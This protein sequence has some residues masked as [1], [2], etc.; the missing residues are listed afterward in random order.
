MNINHLNYLVLTPIYVLLVVLGSSLLVLFICFFIYLYYRHIKMKENIL[1][2]LAT[3]AKENKIINYKLRWVKRKPYDIYYE[4]ITHIYNI[5]V[6]PNYKHKE[7]FLESKT[8][9]VMVNHIEEKK[10]QDAKIKNFINYNPLPQGKKDII[11]IV[12]VYPNAKAIIK[13]I[14]QCELNFIYDDKEVYGVKVI[15]YEN[16]YNRHSIIEGR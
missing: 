12:L 9:W 4:T 2:L 11:K 6:L 3:I 8:K 13:F 14:N 7:L 10:H 16:L 5:R 15:T 1:E